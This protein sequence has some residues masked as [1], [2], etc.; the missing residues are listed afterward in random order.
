ME[1][2]KSKSVMLVWVIAVL[3][4]IAL[5]AVVVALLW[6][7]GK[8]VSSFQE[9]KAAGGVIMESYPEQCAIH[10]KSFT[11]DAQ[12]P[13]GDAGEYVGLTESAALEKAVAAN[14]AARVVERNGESLPVDMSLQPGRLNLY[15]KDDKVYRV[16]IEGKEG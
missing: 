5:V 9:C 14:K 1:R 7:P 6:K 15:V 16:Q 11:N 12:T 13:S 10:G 4:G 8:D 3:C 2:K